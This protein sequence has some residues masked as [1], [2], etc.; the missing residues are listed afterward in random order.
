MSVS[1]ES[2]EGVAN[3]VGRYFTKSLPPY[4]TSRYIEMAVEI[5]GDLLG[6][7][8]YSYVETCVSL[9]EPIWQEK[10]VLFF[11]VPM[12]SLFINQ[13][14]Q[15]PQDKV[16][17]VSHFDIF[18]RVEVYD[19]GRSRRDGVGPSRDKRK[20]KKPNGPDY[21]D[22]PAYGVTWNTPMFAGPH[23]QPDD[24]GL[25]E[26]DV[27]VLVQMFR[28]VLMVG[29]WYQHHTRGTSYRDHDGFQEIEM[30]DTEL[31]TT[32]IADPGADK[33]G[34]STYSDNSDSDF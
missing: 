15:L 27:T 16:R 21:A 24:F 25:N 9:P 10:G 11:S 14:V 20:R 28:L 1:L 13:P 8:S 34:D 22:E 18:D 19:D 2:W 32:L 33:K 30:A 31:Y 17:Y 12:M 29:H 5:I 7:T 23:S 6:K 3:T 26:S 4:Y